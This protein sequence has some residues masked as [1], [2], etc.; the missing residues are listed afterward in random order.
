MSNTSETETDTTPEQA[1]TTTQEIRDDVASR[2]LA[3]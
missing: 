2:V 3:R 1:V